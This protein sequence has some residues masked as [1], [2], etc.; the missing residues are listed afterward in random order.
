MPSP[1]IRR[2]KKAARVAAWKGANGQ[3]EAAPA[4]VIEE[5]VVEAAEEAAPAAVVEEPVVEAAEEAKPVA[6]AA[7]FKPKKKPAKKKAAYKKVE[8][9][10]EG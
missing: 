3:E 5:P 2:L 6:K 8:V 7:P 9:N 10:D 1:R 4:A